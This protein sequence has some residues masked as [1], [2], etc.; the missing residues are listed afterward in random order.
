MRIVFSHRNTTR[1]HTHTQ[2]KQTSKGRRPFWVFLPGYPLSLCAAIGWGG[3]I[4]PQIVVN[5][6][7]T[8]VQLVG[9]SSS[10][11]KHTH[12][13]MAFMCVRANVKNG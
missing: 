10:T 1:T 7:A 6:N 13:H 8:R 3:S 11:H 5:I 12:T 2:G 4:E 9:T